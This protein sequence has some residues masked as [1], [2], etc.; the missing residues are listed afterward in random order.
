MK[1][2]CEND[3]CRY[4]TEKSSLFI[5]HS[6]IHSGIKPYKCDIC[7]YSTNRRDTLKGH[8]LIHS[9]TRN[10][11]CDQCDFTCKQSGNLTVHK[12]IHS[13]L[14]N[15]KC[16]LCELSFKRSGTLSDHKKIHTDIKDLKCDLCEFTCKRSHILSRHKKIHTDIKDF[17]CDLCGYLC[18]RLD[19][20]KD[21]KKSHSDLR[22]FKCDECEFTCIR[23][24]T[25]SRHKKIHMDIKDFKC[26]LCDYSS[27]RSDG[28]N[29]HLKNRHTPGNII[30]R[31]IKEDRLYSKLHSF[32]KLYRELHINLKCDLTSCKETF[33]RVDFV[34]ILKNN[35]IAMIENDENQH[36]DNPQSCEISRMFKAVE[37][38]RLGG[39]TSP[40]VWIRFNPDGFSINGIRQ[41]GEL[42]VP[43]DER[44]D[45]LINVLKELEN[46]V[47]DENTPM[48]RIK[49]LYYDIDDDIIPTVVQ[50]YI[51]TLPQNERE[52]IELSIF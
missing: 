49:Y 50:E 18:K 42:K 4:S 52:T 48:I 3:N 47:I 24:Y 15:F 8:K 1:F 26:A 29:L 32:Y 38:L 36:I 25:L 41:K 10:F 51:W 2:T 14:R 27:S 45:K 35:L 6:R 43:I 19:G 5:R 23:S 20:L 40:V 16:D 13:D 34:T 21:H 44:V 28:L 31:K 39:N 9:N 12:L 11:K 17:K 7:G 46:E 22:N 30:R 33:L 37:A